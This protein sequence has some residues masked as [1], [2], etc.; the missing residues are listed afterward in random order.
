MKLSP[1]RS[2]F[3]HAPF[4]LQHD[5]PSVV[6]RRNICR[7]LPA[8]KATNMAQIAKTEAKKA[9][10]TANATINVTELRQRAADQGADVVQQ[11][12][13]RA[14][15]AAHL[16]ARTLQRMAGAASEA[17]PSAE[18]TTVFGRGFIDLANEQARD[19][20][21]TLKAL[22]G[23]VDWG[24][25]AKAVDWDQVFQIQGEYL[26]ASLER[27]ARLTRRYLE[28]GQAVATSA[29]SAQRQAR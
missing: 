14:E 24:R 29:V 2:I 7:P 8:K 26:R 6:L 17:Q 15:D 13:E 5:S 16:G 3:R 21:A 11:A 20:L 4:A 10:D 9:S 28:L 12:A 27:T 22:T 25:A 18:G 1:H 23:T 19:N